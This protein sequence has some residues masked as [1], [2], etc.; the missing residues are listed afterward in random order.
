MISKVAKDVWK[1][2][3]DD[4]VNVYFLDFEQKIIVDC[5]NRCDSALIDQFLGKVTDF[6]FVE[7]VIFTHLHYDHIGNFDLFP[8]AKFY[9]S[10]E[11]IADFKARKTVT[12]HLTEEFLK[13]LDLKLEVLPEKFNRLELIK[14]PGH[15]RGSIC[16]WY[17]EESILF[18]GDTMFGNKMFGR[19]DLPTSSPGD[20]N[21]SIVK[22]VGYNYRILCSGHDY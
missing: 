8:N 22:L 18:S 17:P 11:E 13:K 20:L 19:T 2:T 16:I 3:G 12:G 5:G 1:F 4:M 9:A 14:T 15:T 6:K 21:K 7:V 10:S